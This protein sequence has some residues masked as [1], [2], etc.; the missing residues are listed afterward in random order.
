[1]PAQRY[2]IQG[3]AALTIDED[4]IWLIFHRVKAFLILL[5]VLLYCCVAKHYCY[6]FRD[7][8]VNEHYLV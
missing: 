6:W 2:I 4:K 1:M 7:E 8:V 5:S 3:A